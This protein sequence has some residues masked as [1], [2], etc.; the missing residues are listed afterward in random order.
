MFGAANTAIGV[1]GIG[2]VAAVYLDAD[3]AV[4]IGLIEAGKVTVCIAVGSYK[5]A[6]SESGG[7]V[8]N[9]APDD[10]FSD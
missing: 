4:P 5:K 9:T 10:V 3:K 2:W 7:K 8:V 6:I 1:G